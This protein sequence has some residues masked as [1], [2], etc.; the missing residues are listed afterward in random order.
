MN[1]V[2]LLTNPT[3]AGAATLAGSSVTIVA[4]WLAWRA[5]VF[6]K[7]CATAQQVFR[8]WTCN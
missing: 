7:K 1:V 3:V 5:N 2:D 6:A 4:A 8:K